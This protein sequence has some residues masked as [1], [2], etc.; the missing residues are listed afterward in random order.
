MTAKGLSDKD[1]IALAPTS[2]PPGQTVG[3]FSTFNDASCFAGNPNLCGIPLRQCPTASKTPE[4][5]EHE[6]NDHEKVWF[7]FVIAVGFATGFWGVI[8]VLIFKKS[9]RMAYFQYAENIMDR[10]YVSVAITVAKLK[11][12]IQRN[13]VEER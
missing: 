6:E 8:G 9:W 4:S 11:R 13:R 12:K 3:Q 7:Y 10:I 2:L 5:S 1:R